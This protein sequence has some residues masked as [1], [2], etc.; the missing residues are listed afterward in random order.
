MALCKFSPLGQIPGVLHI[1]I[2]IKLCLS[3]SPTQSIRQFVSGP[4]TL[5]LVSVKRIFFSGLISLGLDV[6][7][8]FFFVSFK[9]EKEI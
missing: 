1:P 2:F 4:I 7:I 8:S 9:E 5:D 6:V 3:I